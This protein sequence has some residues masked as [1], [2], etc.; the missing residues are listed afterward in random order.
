MGN[1]T[2]SSEK[3]LF[4]KLGVIAGFIIE[5]LAKILNEKQLDYWIQNKTQ[6]KKKLNEVFSI[7]DEYLPE[8]EDWQNFYKDQFGWEVDFSQIIIPIKPAFGNWR[9]IFI[10]KGMTMNFAFSQA[11]W[12]YDDDLDYQVP[13][14]IRNTQN[15][16]AIWV[17]D[18]VEP[19]AEFL[20]KS[21]K[22]ADSDMKLGITVLEGIILE[23]KYYLETDKHL[24]IKGITLCSG[25]RLSDGGVPGMFW[26]SVKFNVNRYL[27]DNSGSGCGIRLAVSL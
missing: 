3:S 8:R 27:L 5:T 4:V 14:N 22:Q 11:P 7:I 19:D 26:D 25:S 13:K 18:E 21:T 10:A 16:Y 1:G 24:N 15:S 9:L 23:M 6:L 2:N 20:G 12:R 17:K